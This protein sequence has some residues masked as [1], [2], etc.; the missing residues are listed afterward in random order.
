MDTK[1]KIIISVMCA[2]F[3][4]LGVISYLKYRES[5][6][7]D[8]SSAN[9]VV[10]ASMDILK[11]TQ[12]DESMLE[13]IEVPKKFVQPGAVL[14][15]DLEGILG[16]VTAA[17]ILR[18]EQIVGTKLLRF[19]KETGL[20]MKVP[21]GMRAVSVIVNN[22]TGVA[23][24]IQPN[25]FV[26]VLATFDF[27]SETRSKQYTYTLI[28]NLPVIA[29]NKDL[30]E[31]YSLLAKKKGIDLGG[32]FLER[33][34]SFAVTLAVTPEQAQNIV[35]AQELGV[36]ALSL[37]GI[38]EG[39]SQ[40]NLAPATPAEMTGNNALLRQVNQPRYMEYKGGR[41]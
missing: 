18:G 21:S 9:F 24:L 13:V 5:K 4:M 16:Q 32:Q 2:V 41:R 6:L 31:G 28:Q 26:D 37:R 19:G 38:G 25:D 33:S 20:A 39:S 35:L 23:G 1:K 22:G 27:G 30:G 7:L 11:H 17:P 36:I 29:V 10:A 3:G 15:S 14:A 34:D 8:M 40:L 12:V